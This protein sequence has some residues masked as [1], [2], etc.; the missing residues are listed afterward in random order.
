MAK[1]ESPD[2]FL[3]YLDNAFCP[4]DAD[5]WKFDGEKEVDIFRP[6]NGSKSNLDRAKT[7]NKITSDA[8]VKIKN[9]VAKTGNKTS[10]AKTGNKTNDAKT[11]NKTSVV[12]HT[13]STTEWRAHL[14]GGLRRC[15]RCGK[16]IL[17]K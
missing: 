3:L 13:A 4:R 12:N 17:K 10:D 5:I 8:R 15:V 16:V 9:S 7:N 11:K 14:R 6:G 1:T 2:D